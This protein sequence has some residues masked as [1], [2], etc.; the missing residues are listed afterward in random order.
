MQA[1][2]IARLQLQGEVAGSGI[3]SCGQVSS[4]LSYKNAAKDPAGRVRLAQGSAVQAFNINQQQV[5]ALGLERAGSGEAMANTDV[6]IV[7]KTSRQEVVLQDAAPKGAQTISIPQ[8]LKLKA[9]STLIVADCGHVL[10][11][12]LIQVWSQNDRQILE[13]A[14]PLPFSFKAGAFARTFEF[15]A[16]YIGKTIRQDKLGNPIKALYVQDAQGYRHELVPDIVKLKL[17]AG[18]LVNGLQADIRA[19][20]EDLDSTQ[21][22][23]IMLTWQ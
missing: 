23:T 17:N 18:T 8:G 9:G 14:Q 19:Q 22:Q 16:F 20:S 2:F 11:D 5:Q 3:T 7:R 10:T 21:E 15:E 12:K 1:L 4:L 13:L 6:L